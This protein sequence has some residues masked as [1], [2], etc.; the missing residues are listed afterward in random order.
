MSDEWLVAPGYEAVRDHFLAGSGSFGRG[1]GAYCAYVD[2]VPV[3]DMWGGKARPGQP[4]QA[5]TTT[6]IMSTSKGLAVLCVQILVDRGQLDLD[7]RVADVWPEFAQ[8]GKGE[9]TIRQVLG[10]TAGVLGFAGQSEITRHDG[11]GFDSYEQISA[12][13]AAAPLSW[14][15]GTKHG[16]H[17][18]SVGWLLAEIVLRVTG[19]T[20]GTFFRV[21]VADPLGL[22]LRIGTPADELGRVAQVYAVRTD[23]LPSFLRKTHDNASAAMRDPN[24]MVGLAFLADGRSSGYDAAEVMFNN[25]AMLAAEFAAGGATADARSL[26]RLWAAMANGGE[27]DGVRLLSPE[28]VDAWSIVVQREPDCTLAEVKTP[29]LAA[30]MAKAPVPRTIGY[31]GNSMVPGLGGRFGPN[32]EAY[33]AEGLGGQ[34]GYCDASSKIAVGY[35]RSELALQDVLQSALTSKVYACARAQGHDVFQPP[36]QSRPAAALG[37]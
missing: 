37:G 6:V 21:E 17:A 11:T 28:S 30:G 36:A 23:Y 2:G 24:K 31:L 33:G 13:L 22:H 7:Q 15:P 3:V 19:K 1:G 10:H 27:L 5:D 18:L 34:Y 16:Y 14:A 35:V 29:R 32:P 8:N 12:G 25:P 26:A 20:V 4:W 9:V